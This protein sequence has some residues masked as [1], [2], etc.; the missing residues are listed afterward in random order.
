MTSTVLVA[1][2]T[3]YLGRQVCEA[4]AETGHRVR[5][6][7]R[8]SALEAPLAQHV[9][10]HHV[11]DVTRPDSLEGACDGVD[12]V[13]SCL[14]ADGRRTRYRDVDYRG[15]LALLEEARRA[16]VGRFVYVS[17]YQG[18]WFRELEVVAAHEDFV[19]ELL[20]SGLESAIIRPTGFFSDLTELLVMA[21]RGRVFV[22]GDG[23]ARLNPIDGRDLA[24]F[25]AE[26]IA[27]GQGNFA[28]GGPEVLSYREMAALA[29]AAVGRPVRVSSVP[30][31]LATLAVTLL[32]ALA[33][34]QADIL[35]FVSTVTRQDMVAP[36]WGKRTLSDWFAEVEAGRRGG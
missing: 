17:M 5:A 33:P 2:A 12:I 16:G 36:K 13:F 27:E 28:V 24:R 6:L 25:C 26:H 19:D 8:R 1:G 22:F 9:V 30:R 3:G 31:P 18:R 35:D 15:N 20:V 34:Q 32:R 10:E 7:S 14:T 29:C 11:G 23:R 4:L 21:R